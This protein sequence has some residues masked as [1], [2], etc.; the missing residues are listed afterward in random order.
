MDFQT[1][2]KYKGWTI[3]HKPNNDPKYGGDWEAGNRE[4]GEIIAAE[5]LEALHKKIDA[6]NSEWE[7]RKH[8]YTR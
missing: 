7:N 3:E 8:W 6:N 5:S 4:S 2:V 1:G